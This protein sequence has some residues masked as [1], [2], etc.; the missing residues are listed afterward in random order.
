MDVGFELL[1]VL[2]NEGSRDVPDN[3]DDERVDG[4]DA[5]RYAERVKECSSAAVASRDPRSSPLC[6][7]F[8]S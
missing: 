2:V 5:D 3:G 4:D 1:G 8:S 6:E 7:R